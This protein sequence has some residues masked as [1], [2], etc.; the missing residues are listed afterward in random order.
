MDWQ[1]FLERHG[2]KHARKGPRHLKAQ[3]PWCGGQ[4]SI[5]TE[6]RGWHCWRNREHRGVSPVRLIAA[7]LGCSVEQAYSLAGLKGAP[8][9]DDFAT[10]AKAL[11][12]G[13]LPQEEAQLPPQL[14]S[15]IRLIDD[16]PLA[17]PFVAYLKEPKRG[18][19]SMREIVK[20]SLHYALHGKWRYRIVFPIYL[21]GEL[22]AMTGRTIV[23]TEK[24]R[25]L[26]EG[27]TPHYLLW[28]DELHGGDEVYLCEGPFDALKLRTLGAD[29]TCLFTNNPSEQQIDLLRDLLPRYNRRFLLLDQ[30]ADIQALRAQSVLASLG[31]EIARLPSRVKD[32]CLLN[33]LDDLR[34]S[35]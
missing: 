8:L 27:H 25:Y 4:L 1:E 26:S 5:S 17:R 3:C 22:V 31:V 32:P 33:N 28:F 13:Q 14:D 2:V 30:D 11:L 9:V 29:A 6:D 18:G 34:K 20:F 10:K 16:S 15:E 21:D 23:R 24:L 19:F 7:L 35:V 12:M